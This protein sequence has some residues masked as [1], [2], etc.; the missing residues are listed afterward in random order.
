VF[1]TIRNIDFIKLTSISTGGIIALA[2]G[3]NWTI[4]KC[5][6]EFQKL[7]SEAFTPRAMHNIPN[8]REIETFNHGSIYKTKQLH[9]ALKKALGE[10]TLFGG[11]RNEYTTFTPKVA[12]TSTNDQGRKAVLIANYNRAS[13]MSAGRKRGK[14]QYEFPRPAN[15]SLELTYWEAAAATSA[16]PP[17]FKTFYHKATGR[18]FLDGAFYNNNPARLA[19]QER[20][21][22]WPDVADHPPDIFLSIGTSKYDEQLNK[23]RQSLRDNPQSRLALTPQPSHALSGTDELCP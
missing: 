3:R 19:Q 1:Y 12:V 17:Y 14:G 7:C 5:I 2:L 22:L 11:K 16:A 10:G 9:E 6:H 15:P 21:I 8:L 4:D 13:K 23:E 20:K 18:S